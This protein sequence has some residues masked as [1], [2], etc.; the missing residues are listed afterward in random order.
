MGEFG[1]KK[2]FGKVDLILHIEGIRQ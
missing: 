2:D 1:F